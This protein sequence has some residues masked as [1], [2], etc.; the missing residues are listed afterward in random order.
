M[1]KILFI[2]TLFVGSIAVAQENP[3]KIV[4]DVTSAD[5]GVHQTAMRH[6]KM[7]SAAYPDSEFELVVYS[8][9]IN[10]VTDG[11]SSVQDDIIALSENDN[12]QIKVCEGTMKRKGITT[13]ELLPGVGTVPDGILEIVTKQGEGWGYIKEAPNN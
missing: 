6:I 1:K 13:N 5:E 11:K 9:A 4:F 7:M 2:L 10:M 12:V 3:V 8:G